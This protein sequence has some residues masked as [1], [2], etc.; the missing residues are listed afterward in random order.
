MDNAFQCWLCSH[1]ALSLRNKEPKIT[2][3]H[4]GHSR[5][6]GKWSFLLGWKKHELIAVISFLTHSA[7]RPMAMFFPLQMPACLQPWKLYV[8]HC[9]L[10]LPPDMGLHL[11]CQ[12]RMFYHW[13]ETS[14]P[15]Y[16]YE[17]L[18][19]QNTGDILILSF[20]FFCYFFVLFCLF[21]S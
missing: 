18:T 6:L 7:G 4:S 8:P 12:G 9:A 15:P 16:E 2:L 17:S 5:Q 20:Y 3:V 19:Y 11:Y 21:S 10:L 1:A 14:L 13:V